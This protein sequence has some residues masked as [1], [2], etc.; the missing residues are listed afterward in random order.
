MIRT[1][2]ILSILCAVLWIIGP[3]GQIWAQDLP[4]PN[5]GGTQP[6]D[7]GGIKPPDGG[8][9][10]PSS[11]GTNPP[12]VDGT[13]PPTGDGTNPPTGDGTNPPTG[14][15]KQPPPGD[16]T[17]LP[18]GDGRNP[19]TGGS[20]GADD[21]AFRELAFDEWIDGPDAGDLD[22]DQDVDE[23]DFKIFLDEVFAGGP[24]E[25]GRP[26]GP[27][28]SDDGG[29]E[30]VFDE[31]VDGPEAADLNG[32]LEIDEDDFK[33]FLD[34]VLEGGPSGPGGLPPELIDFL[35]S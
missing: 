33:I 10:K 32:D 29:R 4:P 22:G 25:P 3:T 1:R 26:G 18:P 6:P 23:E 30:L 7:G 11:G 24:V 13:N 2:A 34:E 9:D 31:W 5:D 12:P 21:G 20:G 28:G 17:N 14:D 27:G 35:L 15:D 16:G 19:P 8:G